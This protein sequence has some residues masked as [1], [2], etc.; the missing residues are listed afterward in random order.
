LSVGFQEIILI[1]V[2]GVFF[3]VIIAIG[4]RIKRG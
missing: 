4:R 2:I 3:A 1:L